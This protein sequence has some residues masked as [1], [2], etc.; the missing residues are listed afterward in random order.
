VIQEVLIAVGL[1]VGLVGC[2]SDPF[3]GMLTLMGINM[4]QPGELYPIFAP[5]H[6]ERVM[7][8]LTIVMVFAK[9]V[10]FRFPRPSRWS[11]IFY[12]ATVASV[13]LAFWVSNAFANIQQFAKTIIL[14]LLLVA[15][16]STPRRIRTVLLL[17]SV[18]VTYLSA[19]SLVQYFQGNFQFRMGVDRAVGLTNA[20]NNPDTLGLTIVTAIP[21]MFLF[22]LKTNPSRLRWLM[23][24]LVVMNLWALMLTGSRGTVLAMVLTLALTA[25]VCKKRMLVIPL[26][27]GLCIAIWAVLPTQYK[28]RYASVG[29]LKDDASYQNRLLSWQGGWHMFL[30][31]PLTGVGIGNYTAANGAKYWPAPRKVYLNAHSI[32]FQTIGEL[33]LVGV[34][35]F[36]GFLVVLFRTNGELRRS[37]QANDPAWRR[38]YPL[39]CNLSLISMLYTGYAY[40]DLYRTTWYF[41]AALS[42][43][44][45]LATSTPPAPLAA[46]PGEAE[47]LPAQPHWAGIGI[48]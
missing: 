35:A 29:N 8:L 17:F 4:I 40:H 24:G 27:A 45:F 13:P 48:R 30:D 14:S 33:G 2:L 6:V 11:L 7:A 46:A 43:A 42:G 22:T 12:G 1:I 34:F 18:L 23:R 19:T 47:A 20:S 26:A 3:F 44:L 28:D 38:Y 36:S 32:Y 37:T 21:L 16:A 41:L 10:K 15:L 5:F 39:A 25:L 9:G 31:H